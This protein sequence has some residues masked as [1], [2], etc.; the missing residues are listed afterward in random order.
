MSPDSFTGK[1]TDMRNKIGSPRHRARLG[2]GGWTGLY[3]NNAR[4]AGNYPDKVN[5][6]GLPGVKGPAA[7]T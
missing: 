6:V 5:V 2:L 4:S 1:T 3:N 7:N